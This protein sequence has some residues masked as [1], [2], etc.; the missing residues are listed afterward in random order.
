MLQSNIFASQA[1]SSSATDPPADPNAE[2][3]L[4]D[5]DD[6]AGGSR[7][8]DAADNRNDYAARICNVST[9]IIQ[10]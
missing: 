5:G 1:F 9:L 6:K 7:T 2:F 10:I 4:V 8:I 3:A